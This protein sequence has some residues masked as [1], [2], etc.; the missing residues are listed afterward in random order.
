MK[1]HTN[2][3]GVDCFFECVGKNQTI[4]LAIEHTAPSGKVMLIG[5]PFEDLHLKK[6]IYWKILRCQLQIFGTW[7]SSFLHTKEDDWNYVLRLLQQK[8]ISP[9]KLISHRFS[10]EE[11][12][13]GLEIMR[14]KT[15]E[16]GKIII[17]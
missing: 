2:H 3:L 8:K 13:T 15:E 11:L 5:N 12:E 7:N 9:T 10:L 14:D 17:C 16:Y 1:E 6:E 4:S